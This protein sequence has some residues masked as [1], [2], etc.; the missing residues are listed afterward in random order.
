MKSP[1]ALLKAWSLL[2]GDE[3]NIRASE[4]ALM[5]IAIEH[6]RIHAGKAWIN[7]DEYFV[8]PNTTANYLFHVDSFDTSVHVRNFGFVSDQ[9]LMKLHFYENP[10]VDVNSEGDVLSL[11]S[12][13]RNAG[14]DSGL[15]LHGNPFIDTNSLGIHLDFILQPES[16]IGNQSAG[17]AAKNAVTE[18]LVNNDYYYLFTLENTT[19]NTATIESQFFVYRGD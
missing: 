14:E 17:G 4:N 19:V 16:A 7:K 18:W 12:M 1:T 15:S 10:F 11:R 9:G 3:E 13:N 6:E 5:M 8:P 2:I